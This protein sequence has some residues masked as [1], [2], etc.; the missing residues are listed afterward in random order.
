MNVTTRWRFAAAAL[1]I[2]LPAVGLWLTGTDAAPYLEFPPRT[3]YIRHEPFSWPAFVALALLLTAVALRVLRI[4]VRHAWQCPS[5]PPAR[6]FPSWGWHGVLLG[7]LAW[8]LAWTRLPHAAFLQP[9]TFIPLWLAYIVVMNALAWRRTGDCPMLANP[10]RYLALFPLSAVF[11][12]YFEYLNRF[13]QNWFYEGVDGFGPTGY[14]VHATLAFAT[15]LPAVEATAAWLASYPMLTAGLDSAQPVHPTRVRRNAR[16]ALLAGSTVLLALPLSPNELYPVLWLA[17]LAV[18]AATESLAG[19]STPF[20]EAARGDWRTLLRYALAALVCGFFW[21]FWNHWSY[22]RWVYE[23]SYVGR[24]RVFEMPV[25][26]FAGYLPFGVE[27]ALV[28]RW[29]KL[30][31]SPGRSSSVLSERRPRGF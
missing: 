25:L 3:R 23:V 1:C 6:R 5:P 29:C 18:L 13:V 28:A 7:A 21:E 14:V 20:T 16:C 31:S 24:F 12:W 2:V 22:A 30:D 19:H 11:W 10:R 4:V 27:C 26:G 9:Y 17:P 8:T 15:V